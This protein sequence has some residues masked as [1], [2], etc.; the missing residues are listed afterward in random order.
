MEVFACLELLDGW[1][2]QNSGRL[3]GSAG[4]LAPSGGTLVV[5][6]H[7]YSRLF[8]SF[9]K[10]KPP[11]AAIRAEHDDQYAALTQ[12]ARL[13]GKSH[14]VV[15][16]RPRLHLPVL[17][18]IL[19]MVTRISPPPFFVLKWLRCF[20]KRFPSALRSQ[21]RWQRADAPRWWQPPSHGGQAQASTSAGKQSKNPQRDG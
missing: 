1:L 13:S 17:L 19:R 15:T 7:T 20:R 4:S 12:G 5:R 16:Q 6:R 9:R 8:R 2:L 21:L 14:F 3:A 18:T 10:P 11:Q